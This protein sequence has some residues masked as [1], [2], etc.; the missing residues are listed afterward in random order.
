MHS[1][2]SP[3]SGFAVSVEAS[4]G[5]RQFLTKPGATVKTKS[6]SR[7]AGQILAQDLLHDDRS[8]HAG[9]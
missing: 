6:G 2:V 8:G 1:A 9:V 5:V 4:T 3:I 7:V